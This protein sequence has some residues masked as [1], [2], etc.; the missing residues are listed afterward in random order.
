VVEAASLAVLLGL[1]KSKGEARRLIDNR[2]IRVD[3]EVL[4]DRSAQI[5]VRQARVFQVGRNAFVKVRF[6]P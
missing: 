3:G 2:G 4:S 1:A 6:E 5:D